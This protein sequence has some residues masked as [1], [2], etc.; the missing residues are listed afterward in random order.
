M[1]YRFGQIYYGTGD[2]Q[3]AVDRLRRNLHAI[4]MDTTNLTAFNAFV[5][6]RVYLGLC[7]AELGDFA[8]GLRLL[9][10]A[11]PA[12]QASPLPFDLAGVDWSLGLL[13]IRQGDLLRARPLLESGFTLCQAK[14]LHLVEPIIGSLLGLARCG[15]GLFETGI[16]LLEECARTGEGIFP[17]SSQVTAN[18]A[19]GYLL[20]DRQQEAREAAARALAIAL[21][22]SERGHEGWAH[23]LLGDISARSDASQ[24]E[25][26][27][28]HYQAAQII[29]NGGGMRP[30]V[31]RCHLGLSKL[32]RC[33]GERG[34]ATDHLTTA[35]ALYREM[36]TTYW[37][38][39]A[40]ARM[41]C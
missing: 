11:L 40:Q 14:N 27:A 35:T 37:L 19:E 20:A 22:H 36:G 38:E 12:G 8:E 31:A 7:L 13:H 41:R 2:Y 32:Y 5:F 17:F 23:C 28:A 1:D 15:S 26:A 30:L 34:R 9:H 24:M 39:Q 29:G 4:P 33:T 3:G 6:W 25:A 18:L 21:A 10:E 16:P